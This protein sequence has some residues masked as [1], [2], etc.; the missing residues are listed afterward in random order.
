M[1]RTK[2]TIAI[3]LAV[4]LCFMSVCPAMGAEPYSEAAVQENDIVESADEAAMQENDVME[5]DSRDGNATSES[6]D[7]AETGGEAASETD[8]A[9][10]GDTVEPIETIHSKDAAYA[11]AGADEEKDKW[12]SF[13]AVNDGPTLN[14]KFYYDDSMMLTDAN[15][16]SPDLAKVAVGLASAAYIQGDIVQCF[17]DMDYELLGGQSYNYGKSTT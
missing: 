16:L 10:V 3:I 4:V 17:R 13:R 5:S 9:E 2:S 8:V 12:V 6:A 11:T 14:S 15:V 1:K 7:E